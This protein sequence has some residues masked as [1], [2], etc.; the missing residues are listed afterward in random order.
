MKLLKAITKSSNS[1][2]FFTNICNNLKC[3]IIT[4][5]KILKYNQTYIKYCLS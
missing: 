5:N 3:D 1:N 4:F 2:F